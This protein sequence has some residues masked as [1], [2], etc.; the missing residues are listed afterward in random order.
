MEFA[1]SKGNARVDGS[2]GITFGDVGGLGNTI[3]AMEEVVEVRGAGGRGRR[4]EEA[5]WH[6]M[7]T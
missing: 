2:T 7:G 1:Q 3:G 6:L 4:R 5:G